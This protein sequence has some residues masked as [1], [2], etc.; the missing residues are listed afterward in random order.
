[1]ADK[2]T[3]HFSFAE[4]DK[5]DKPAPF[6]YTTKASK[7]VTFPDVWDMEFEAAE[8]FLDDL[9]A[10]TNNSA[11]LKK[12]LSEEDYAKLRDDRLSLRAVGVLV[13]RVQ[14]HYAGALG[15]SGEGAA[16]AS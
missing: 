9:N 16:S 15:S 12:W 13:E 5:I 7:R 1:M 2:P 6:T 11:V 14:A 10:N 8:A 3:T 4:L